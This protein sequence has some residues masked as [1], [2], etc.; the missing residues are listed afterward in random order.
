MSRI[1]D[2]LDR[3]FSRWEHI[4]LHGCAD[5][6]WPDGVNIN[7]KRNHIIYGYRRLAEEMDG[8]QLDLISPAGFK[9]ERYGL[10]PIPPEMP[11]DWMCPTGEYPD[12]L[13]RR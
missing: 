4:F 1:R 5:P 13:K 7:L 6:S 10:R 3:D 11:N 9:P 2:E 12:R 8:V